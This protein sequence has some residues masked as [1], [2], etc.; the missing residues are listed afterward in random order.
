[1]PYGLKFYNVTKNSK[2][3]IQKAREKEVVKNEW[4]QHQRQAKNYAPIQNAFCSLGK[5][6]Q[7][8]STWR[9]DYHYDHY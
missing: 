9:E 8:V 4:T 7:A 1:M 3:S 2:R 5:I 6:V